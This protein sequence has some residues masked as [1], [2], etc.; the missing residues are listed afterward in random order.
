LPEWRRDLRGGSLEF[1]A[2]GL[3]LRQTAHRQALYCPLFIDLDERRNG[4]QLT[5]RQLTVAQDRR[6]VPADIAA[7]YRVQ[8][9]K[10]QFVFYRSLGPAANRTLLGCNLVTEC[11]AGRFTKAGEVETI[12]EIE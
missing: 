7:G 1:D 5:W 12:L 9:A 6:A 10:E 4:G 2:E 3:H 8:V 11:M